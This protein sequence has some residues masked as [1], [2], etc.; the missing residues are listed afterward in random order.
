MR[1]FNVNKAIGLAS[2][3]VEYAQKYRRQIF[4]DIDWVDDYYIF[5]DYMGTNLSVFSDRLGFARAQVLGIY[6]LVSGR[7]TAP[8]AVGVD[9]IVSMIEQPHAAPQTFPGYTDVALTDAAVRYR[10][11]TVGS[12]FVDRLETR[13]ILT[14]RMQR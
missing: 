8:C 5:T 9:E 1:V 10:V 7:R 4:A 11:R 6:D 3:G 13:E 12:G 14:R 2:S